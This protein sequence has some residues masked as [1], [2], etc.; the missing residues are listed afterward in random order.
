LQPAEN[1]TIKISATP[2]ITKRDEKIL[3]IFGYFTD[4]RKSMP[5]LVANRCIC[6]SKGL[7]I[8]DGRTN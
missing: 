3:S 1:N 2:I 4:L 8:G 5:S 7:W 6:Y